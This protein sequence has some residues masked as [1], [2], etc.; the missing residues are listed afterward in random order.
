MYVK[1]EISSSVS[2]FLLLLWKDQISLVYMN[3]VPNFLHTDWTWADPSVSLYYSSVSPVLMS[4]TG[5]RWAAESLCSAQLASSGIQWRFHREQS[6]APSHLLLALRGWHSVT[7]PLSPIPR[8]IFSAP[9]EGAFCLF[10]YLLE[11]NKRYQEP[12]VRICKCPS[13]LQTCEMHNESGERN[14][15]FKCRSLLLVSIIMHD[16]TT[17]NELFWCSHTA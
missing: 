17:G 12:S 5:V 1:R 15:Y 3:Y 2:L 10:I 13:H 14:Y 6:S 4:M 7:E 16:N 9:A 8:P 11:M